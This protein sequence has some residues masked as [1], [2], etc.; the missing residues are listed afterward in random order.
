VEFEPVDDAPLSPILDRLGLIR[1]KRT[2]GAAFRFG[3]VNIP[4]S[5]FRVIRAAL[6][7]ARR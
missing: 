2:Y 6:T 4:E 7:T 5:G 1:N 3:V